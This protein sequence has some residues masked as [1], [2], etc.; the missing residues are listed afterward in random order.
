MRVFAHRL[1]LQASY[2]A[3]N[4]EALAM[5]S[6]IAELGA[7]LKSSQQGADEMRSLVARAETE[8]ERMRAQLKR[9]SDEL[10]AANAQHARAVSIR[11]N[12]SARRS[13]LSDARFY[14]SS[15]FCSMSINTRICSANQITVN[16]Q[17]Q[18]TLT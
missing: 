14:E 18:V 13:R 4:R 7:K 9:A 5:E 6:T 15:C 2:E 12:W 16:P 1:Q 8:L 17:P 3:R 10:D 11:T